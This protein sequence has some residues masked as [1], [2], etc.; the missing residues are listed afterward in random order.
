MTS[1]EHY[2]EFEEQGTVFAEGEP[3]DSAYIVEQGRVELYALIS[4]ESVCIAK[5][6]EGDLFGEMAL[7]D[8]QLRSATAIALP[9]TRLIAIPRKYVEDRID[10][11]DKL[12]SMLLRVVL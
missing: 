4:G 9:D 12:V 8:N 3:G 2:L 1:S 5:L 10:V 11:S 6:R 7:I